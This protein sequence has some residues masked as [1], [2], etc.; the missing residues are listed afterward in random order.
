MFLGATTL[1]DITTADVKQISQE[2][3]E[4]CMMTDRSSKLQWP[5][6]PYLHKSQINTWKQFICQTYVSSSL[7]L[8]TP[9]GAWTKPSNMEWNACIDT[10]LTTLYYLNHQKRYAHECMTPTR[11]GNT[12]KT[13]G[14]AT[15]EKPPSLSIPAATSHTTET[16]GIT[17]RPSI[18]ANQPPCSPQS[19]HNYIQSLPTE[20]ECLL[21]MVNETPGATKALTRALGKHHSTLHTAT[22][23]SLKHGMGTFGW[24]IIDGYLQ[25]LFEGA[26]PVDSIT[27]LASSTRSELYGI[28]A[29][30]EFLHR[31]SKYHQI[32]IHSSIRVRILCDSES[33][34][35]SSTKAQ[36]DWKRHRMTSNYDIISHIEQ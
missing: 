19:W 18:I 24:K 29:I 16:I 3:I 4:G 30:L 26:G 20:S 7:Y 2:A 9:L 15:Y 31:F 14:E 8:R 6:Q 32:T 5:S 33:A 36:N 21:A 28:G 11:Q 10:N 22:D 25:E 17:Y 34:I 1:S 27:E 23:G 12:C 35:T 13:T